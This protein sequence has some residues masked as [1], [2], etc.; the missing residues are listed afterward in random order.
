[1][2]QVLSPITL[3]VYNRPE[4]TLRT[5]EA[6]SRNTLA[7]ESRLIIFSDGPKPDACD[8]ELQKL[9]A[10]RKLIRQKR[11]CGEVKIVESDTNKGLADSIRRGVDRV[12]EEH[13]RVIV[14]EDDL[15]TSPGFLAYMNDALETYELEDR[16]FQV[17]GFMVN[18]RPWSHATGFLRV[19]TSWGWATWQR[20]W[21]HYCDSAKDLL[22]KV[23][24]KGCAEFD[25]GGYS[26]HFDELER[27]VNGD[28]DTWAVKWYASIFLNDGLCLYPRK[29]LVRNLGFDGSGTHCE[30]SK[31]TFY[32]RMRIARN[33]SVKRVTIIEDRQ[34]LAAMQRYYR[35]LLREWTGMRTRDRIFKKLCK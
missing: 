35:N 7:S 31:S 26:F 6:L 30:A 10:V 2:T 23:K 5:L 34:Y 11:W 3:F 18:N 1:M 9:L 25:L 4:H 28:L 29:S 32:R 20:A 17:S 22:E 21:R 14:L 8:D 19:S 27:N 16:V 12:L 24:V 13:D 33:H 15:E